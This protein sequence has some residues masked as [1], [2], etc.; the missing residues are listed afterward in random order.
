MLGNKAKLIAA[1]V[2][3][4]LTVGVDFVSSIFSII[5]DAVLIGLA[6][7]LLWPAIKKEFLE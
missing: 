6:L 4:L 2:F 7:L 3:L 5:A 1:I